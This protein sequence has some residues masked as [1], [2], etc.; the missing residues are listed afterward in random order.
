MSED[1]QGLE[2]ILGT[3]ITE[4]TP[5]AI[6]FSNLSLGALEQLLDQGYTREDKYY[7][8]SPTIAK[9]IKFGKRC[10]EMRAVAT[11]DG[12]GFKNQSSD[13]A[14]DAIEVVGVKDLDFAGEFIKFVQGCDEIEVSSEYLFAWW[15]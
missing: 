2:Q 7:N 6:K 10:V 3:T 1:S 8:G 12:V 15:D 14:I 4:Y 13:V 9:F 5:N 11:F